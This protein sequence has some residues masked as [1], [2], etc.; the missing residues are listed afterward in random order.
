M[1][2]IIDRLALVYM[3]DGKVLCARSKDRDFFYLPG[4]ERQGDESD[5]EALV[6]EIKEELDVDLIPSSIQKYK[7]FEG[8][9]DAKEEGTI[10]R[11]TCYF[12]NIKGDIHMA[13]EIAEIDW[14]GFEDKY[15][16]PEMG[17]E[18]FDDL[19]KTGLLV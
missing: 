9:A 6:R 7:V 18:V 16:I 10:V 1:T 5:I 15:R 4:G 14:L 11:L 12:A 8:Q 2:K 13:N 3:Q 19:K 17:Y